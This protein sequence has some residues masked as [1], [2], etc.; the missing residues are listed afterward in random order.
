[1]YPFPKVT[2]LM[3]VYNASAFLPEAIDSILQQTFT[4]FEF[5]IINDGSTDHSEEII[6]GF[7]DVRIKYIK[8]SPNRGIVAALNTGLDLA[9]GTYIARMDADDIAAENRIER[10][11]AF[12]DR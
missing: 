5:I 12:M 1:M 4:D 9:Q 7:D 2:V 8:V 3:P 11:V 10:Q 6:R